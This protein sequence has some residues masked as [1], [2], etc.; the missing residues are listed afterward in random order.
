MKVFLQIS[1]F[2]LFIMFALDYFVF[3]KPDAQVET[4]CFW[5]VIVLFRILTVQTSK[6]DNNS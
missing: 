6:E 4:C 2:V 1:H 3:S 5:A